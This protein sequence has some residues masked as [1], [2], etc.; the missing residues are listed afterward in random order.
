MA[1]QDMNI[2]GKRVGSMTERVEV[3]AWSPEQRS[4]VHSVSSMGDMLAVAVQLWMGNH[5][6]LH[7][8]WPG[9]MIDSP[10]S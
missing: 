1:G 9:G 10:P 7:R 8:D 4:W 3:P 2:V 5:H 6:Q